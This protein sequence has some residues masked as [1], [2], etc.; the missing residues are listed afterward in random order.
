MDALAG[1]A[2]EPKFQLY[3]MMVPVEVLVNV[4][5]WPRQAICVDAV[6]S[7]VGVAKTFVEKLNRN[8]PVRIEYNWMSPR[9]KILS[10]GNALSFFTFVRFRV[11]PKR[12]RQ[13]I[14]IVKAR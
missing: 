13:T 11:G 6:K 3:E 12:R 1:E 7:A 9:E 2:P 10:H 8:M 5:F 4:T 14:N